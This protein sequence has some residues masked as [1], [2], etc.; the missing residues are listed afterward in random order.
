[1]VS[2]QRIPTRKGNH[3]GEIKSMDGSDASTSHNNLL[4]LCSKPLSVSTSRLSSSVLIPRRLCSSDLKLN[5]T[6]F[7][8]RCNSSLGPGGPGPD[9]MVIWVMR[10][11]AFRVGVH[12]FSIFT[13][14]L[15]LTLLF[16]DQ[17]FNSSENDSRSVLD[18]F[19]LGKA[20]AE[21]LNERIESTV[22]EF[23][24]TIGRLQAEQ[25][26]QVQ[27]FQ[28]DVFERAKR[29]KEKAARE[30][31]EAQG[32]VPK[33][34]TANGP[35][36]VDSDTTANVP[37]AADATTTAIYPS[38]SNSSGPDINTDPGPNDKDSLLGAS[39]ED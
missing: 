24:S 1:M 30:A 10:L 32:L 14:K 39:N 6:R 13:E 29:E 2:G 20:L 9:L 37:S 5:P 26:K 7:S 4:M 33:S 8:L 3:V 21:A 28:E 16:V 38:L 22:G 34:S 36:V 11:G 17:S 18:A 15:I 23:L 12:S 27:D 31:M 19:F 25:Q 35:A